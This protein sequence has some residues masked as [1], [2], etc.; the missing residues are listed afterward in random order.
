MSA[1]PSSIRILA[2]DDHVLLRD[3]IAALVAGQ[4]DISNNVGSV[5]PFFE[6]TS[7]FSPK[8]VFLFRFFLVLSSLHRRP[9]LARNLA[10][11]FSPT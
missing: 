6:R 2:V 3:G 9:R 10:V 1:D 8:R 11:G 7:F 4:S 5:K